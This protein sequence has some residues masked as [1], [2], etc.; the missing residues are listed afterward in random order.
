MKGKTFNN[1]NFPLALV[2]LK[3]EGTFL[4]V[5]VTGKVNNALLYSGKIS[6]VDV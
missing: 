3:T 2:I 1:L 4:S 6:L 5:L